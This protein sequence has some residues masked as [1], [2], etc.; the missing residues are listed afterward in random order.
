MDLFGNRIHFA[1]KLYLHEC[2]TLVQS[3]N[4]NGEGGKKGKAEAKGK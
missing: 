3:L 2:L 4:I 1:F